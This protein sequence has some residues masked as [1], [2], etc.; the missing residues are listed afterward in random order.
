MM[1]GRDA[2][3]AAGQRTCARPL[4]WLVELS[5]AGFPAEAARET[6]ARVF[7]Y[8]GIRP[9]TSPLTPSGCPLEFTFGSGSRALAYTLEPA[10]A[11]AP[12][13]AKWRAVAEI[14]GNPAIREGDDGQLAMLSAQEGQRY[15]C[16]L[17][18][19]HGAESTEFKIYQ[20]VT[21]AAVDLARAHL[22]RALPRVSCAATLE[23]VLIGWA[24]PGGPFEYYSRVPRPRPDALHRLLDVT[25][26]T[27]QLPLVIGCLAELAGVS[28]SAVLKHVR[29]GVSYRVSSG[30]GAAVTL[31]G[32]ARQLCPDEFE[33][34]RRLLALARAL[35]V[36]FTGYG[37][38][39]G[40]LERDEPPLPVHGMVGLTMGRDERIDLSV[41]V[42]PPWA[43]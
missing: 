32:H 36:D 29:L 38:A 37:L 5:A 14:T 4:P 27:R 11:H 39:T 13:E 9:G 24:L 17:G 35:C 10:G 15:G 21:P 31:F 40:W 2:L 42:C 16:W 19:R 12:I 18:V 22:R 34:R 30:A 28:R 1:A 23:P 25:G 43:G 41:G 7:G 20:E 26:A 8:G 3:A 6:L 33:L